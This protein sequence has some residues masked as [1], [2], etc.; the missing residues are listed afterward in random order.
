MSIT[1]QPPGNRYWVNSQYYI[2]QQDFCNVIYSRENICVV[3]TMVFPHEFAYKHIII[4]SLY[5]LT[6][7]CFLGLLPWSFVIHKNKVIRR[8]FLTVTSLNWCLF[9]VSCI[10]DCNSASNEASWREY[11]DLPEQSESKLVSPFGQVLFLCWGMHVWSLCIPD[12]DG[13][14]SSSWGLVF[15]GLLIHKTYLHHRW[16]FFLEW[17]YSLF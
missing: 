4:H 8:Y 1:Y 2:L 12:V 10:W 11:W 6:H 7:I 5:N 9:C 16:H 17:N 15:Q 3:E 13:P 14:C